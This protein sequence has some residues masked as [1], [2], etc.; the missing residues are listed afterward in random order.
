MA[1]DGLRDSDAVLDILNDLCI[2]RS[3]RQDTTDRH[4]FSDLLREINLPLSQ[5][6]VLQTLCEYFPDSPHFWNHLGRHMAFCGSGSFEEAEEMLLKAIDLDRKSDVHHHALGM[7][8]RK[9]VQMKLREPLSAGETA[10]D[11]LAAISP[12]FT[13]A[14]QAFEKARS[15]NPNSQYPL[16]SPIQMIVDT[17]D[18]LR[19]YGHCNGDLRAVLNAPNQTGEWCR[20]KLAQAQGLLA[21]LH[22]LEAGGEPGPYRVKCDSGVQGALGNYEGM[23]EGLSGLLNRPDVSHPPIRRMLASGH[24]QRVGVEEGKDATKSLRQIVKLMEAN[25]KDDPCNGADIRTWFRAY[26]ALPEFSLP[27]ALE[28]VTEWSLNSDEADSKYYLY[29]LHFIAAREGYRKSAQECLQNIERCRRQ[30]PILQ[31]KKSFEWW[32]S[33]VLNRPC[34]LVHHSE[35]GGW[36]KDD[37][38]FVGVEKLGY[39]E[40]RI[41]KISAPQAGE[42]DIGGIPAFFAPKNQFI[43]ARDLNAKIKCYLG[44]SYEG[45]RAWSVQPI[46]D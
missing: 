1:T 11:R 42:L 46:R 2:E 27:R 35:L 37:D 15:C 3:F 7:V 26:R 5:R 29:I 9:D 14:E 24:L 13:K 22:H 44:F 6:R 10:L 45:L 43:R 21:I 40:G 33:P 23:I 36:S 18:W 25:L 34:P 28:Q 17:L 39:V 12:C 20:G 30:A 16:V 31:A 32:A 19:R 38:F 8:Y 4:Q 41:D